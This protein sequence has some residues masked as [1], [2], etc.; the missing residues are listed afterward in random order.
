MRIATVMEPAQQR[1]QS[2][3]ELSFSLAGSQQGS[4]QLRSVDES[5]LDVEKRDLDVLR[6]L[7]C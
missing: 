7:R 6:S 4:D 5:A 3:H 2:I 1:R